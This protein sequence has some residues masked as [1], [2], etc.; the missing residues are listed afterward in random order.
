MGVPPDRV[1]IL[2]VEDDPH[3][4][5]LLCDVLTDEGYAVMTAATSAEVHTLIATVW[6]ALVT[7][8]LDLPGIA[9]GL[10]LLIELRRRDD[11]RDLPVVIVSAAR[12]IPDEVRK[13]AQAVVPK[14]FNLDDLLDTI[15]R[16]V[17]PPLF[18]PP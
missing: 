11:T 18:A 8:D 14:P 2:V 3:V 15:R 12:V 5:D 7:L 4:S 13:M 16:F 9:S 10:L 6:P 1:A 17:S